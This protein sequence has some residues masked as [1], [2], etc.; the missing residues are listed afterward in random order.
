MKFRP[1]LFPC[2]L[3]GLWS[4]LS[5]TGVVSEFFMATPI[6]TVRALYRLFWTGEILQDLVFTIGRIFC[7]LLIGSVGGM[8]VGC[9]IGISPRVWCYVEGTVDFFRSL[10]AFALFPFFILVFG[11]GDNAKVATTAWFV[12]FIMLIASAYAIRSTSSTRLNAARALGATRF[13]AFLY[14]VVPD[15]IPQLMVGFRTALAFAPIVV[16]AT[17]MFSGTRYGLGNRIY[18]ARLVYK[19]PEMYATLIVAGLVGYGLNKSFTLLCGRLVHWT[20]K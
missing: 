11:P 13:Q 4:L 3:L 14:V 7:G 15:G 10:P 20:G 16:V 9:A 17:E 5:Y 6:D 19:V 1:I 12:A 8:L 2:F 18:E